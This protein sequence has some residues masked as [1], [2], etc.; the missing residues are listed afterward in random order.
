MYLL[1]SKDLFCSASSLNGE[2]SP[3]EKMAD[4]KP[5]GSDN[6]LDYPNILYEGTNIVS[7]S[8]MGVVFATGEKPFL[9]I[10]PVLLL[11]IKTK[12]QL[13]TLELKMFLKYY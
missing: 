3:V 12:R 5:K 7:G 10:W 11:R 4:Q 8:G 1:K 9:E 13:L 6:Y 2:S